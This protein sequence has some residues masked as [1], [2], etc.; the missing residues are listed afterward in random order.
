MTRT[1]TCRGWFNIKGLHT[2][3]FA[4]KNTDDTEEWPPRFWKFTLETK[5]NPKVEAAFIDSRRFGRIRLLDCDG[6]AIRKTTPLKENGPD[7]VVDRDSFTL[8]WFEKKML[9]KKVPV[10]ALYVQ[11]FSCSSYLERINSDF[12]QK[13]ARSSKY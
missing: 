3:K 8:E 13:D 4:V 2:G 10:K 5:E 9:S 11:I 6:A 1:L 12:L 7:P